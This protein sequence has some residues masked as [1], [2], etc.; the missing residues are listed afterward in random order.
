MQTYT[1]KFPDT[2][3]VSTTLVTKMDVNGGDVVFHG[4]P[5]DAVY[6]P[7]IEGW[8]PHGFGFITSDV[9]NES[10]LDKIVHLHR[11]V[12]YAR[13]SD[14]QIEFLVNIVE[15]TLGIFWRK[16]KPNF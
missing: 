13:T 16:Q 15:G 5:I 11:M 12:D 2:L 4:E 9:N 8:L 3:F 10:I 14:Y 1:L 6:K 7:S